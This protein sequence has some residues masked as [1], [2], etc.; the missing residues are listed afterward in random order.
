[1]EVMASCLIE[2]NRLQKKRDTIDELGDE[3]K[4]RIE[5]RLDAIWELVENGL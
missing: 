5:R 4:I 3:E 2:W 1:M